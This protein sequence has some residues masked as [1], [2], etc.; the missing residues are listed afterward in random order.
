MS[1][2]MKALLL[3]IGAIVVI[4]ILLGAYFASQPKVKW[5]KPEKDMEKPVLNSY[6]SIITVYRNYSKED[7]ILGINKYAGNFSTNKNFEIGIVLRC[8]EYL[9]DINSYD[10]L[11]GNLTAYAERLSGDYIL[12][13]LVIRYDY[14][15]DDYVH[16]DIPVIKNRIKSTNLW[17]D[18][19]P[20]PT[21]NYMG[22]TYYYNWLYKHV[23]IG[24]NKDR[25]NENFYG[26]SFALQINL[27]DSLSQHLNHTII[28]TVAAYYGHPS[29]LGWT[30]MHELKT[31][32]VLKIVAGE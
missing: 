26:V 15:K 7:Y 25:K 29:L 18:A 19:T 13:K 32:V 2:R 22:E 24:V 14:G 11:G 3:G 20:N 28:L 4:A 8:S 21:P 23:L 6:P 9:Y 1:K 10:E 5:W 30:D 27:D 12:Q 17:F 31:Q 16:L